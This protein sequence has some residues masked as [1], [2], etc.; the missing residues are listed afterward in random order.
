MAFIVPDEIES[1]IHAHIS[2]LGGQFEALAVET[3]ETLPYPQMQV[4]PIEGR[5]LRMLVQI[6]GA[7]RILEI[8]T[9]SGYSALAMASAL[10]SDGSIITC[11]IDP[12]ATSVAQRYFDKVSYG[13]QIEIRLGAALDTMQALIDARAQFDLVF[14]DADKGNYS[15]YF[16]AAM[17]LIP[18][19]G[20]IVI[21][22]ALWS[23]AVLNPETD[24]ALAIRQLNAKVSED[25]R[26]EQVLLSVRDGIHIARKVA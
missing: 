22:N 10:P 24:D 26:V 20:L 12:V 9:Y 18:L 17:R 15:A 5:L 2:S 1:Y 8:G 21:D 11:D 19:G 16:D 3:R 7:K 13:S 23:G 25:P 6:S 4:G 14:I